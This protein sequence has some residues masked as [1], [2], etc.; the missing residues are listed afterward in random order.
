MKREF[1]GRNV[2][3]SIAET[4]EDEKLTN[5]EVHFSGPAAVLGRAEGRPAPFRLSSVFATTL[6][7]RVDLFSSDSFSTTCQ[8]STPAFQTISCGASLTAG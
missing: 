6:L 3:S 5:M 4:K 1:I 2:K 8:V 7:N